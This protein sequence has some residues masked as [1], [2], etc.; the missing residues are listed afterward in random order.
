MQHI[1]HSELSS[2]AAPR[3]EEEEKNAEVEVN[4]GQW[5][6]DRG[7]TIEDIA[8]GMG[9]MGT[10]NKGRRTEERKPGTEDR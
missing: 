4:V 5:T 10:E 7:M 9:D 3:G 2:R 1:N 6:E 8:Q